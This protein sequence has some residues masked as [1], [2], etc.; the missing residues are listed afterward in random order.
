MAKP[1]LGTEGV[2]FIGFRHGQTKERVPLCLGSGF[3]AIC[4]YWYTLLYLVAVDN[5]VTSTVRTYTQTRRHADTPVARVYRSPR[6]D[7]SGGYWV[8]N[9]WYSLIP[10]N[11]GKAVQHFL[12]EY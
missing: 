5:S 6:K 12:L 1:I 9:T 10:Y 3:H 11:T 4:Y 2:Q 7:F 8:I